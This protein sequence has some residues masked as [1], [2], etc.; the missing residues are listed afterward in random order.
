MTP[1]SFTSMKALDDRLKDL[2]EA[3]R[4]SGDL[5]HT[6]VFV[7][8]DHGFRSFNKVVHPNT[9]LRE[10][11]WVR[12][13]GSQI[14][15]DAWVLGEGGSALVYVTNKKM[16]AAIVPQLTAL[17]A[18]TEGVDHV[19]MPDY[20]A[21]QGIPSAANSDQ[22]PALFLTAKPDY[23]LEGGD[24]GALV[25][26]SSGHG[27]HGYSN[28]DPK[29][30]ALFVAWGAAVRGGVHLDSIKN[31]DVAPTIAR[32]L[33]IKMANVQGRTLSEILR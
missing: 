33:G 24:T 2:L 29:M 13:E 12:G 16:K 28:T 1:A 9:L 26:I 21:A 27:T 15:C 5:K 11:G 32:I 23:T 20:F 30:G 8:S 18:N 31:L 6:T 14:N 3:V 7:V 10:K 17:F 22:S 25:T 4:S 19:Y